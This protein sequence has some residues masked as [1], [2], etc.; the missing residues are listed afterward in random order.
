[1]KKVKV[2]TQRDKEY[3]VDATD[4]N[5]QEIVDALNNDTKITLSIGNMVKNKYDIKMIYLD[6]ESTEDS[7]GVKMLV[8]TIEGKQH[9]T[10][11]KDYDPKM[12]SDLINST[13]SLFV[14]VGNIILWRNS[15]G[16]IFPEPIEEVVE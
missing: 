6:G 12:L 13:G 8:E 4:Y 7:D 16:L 3:T 15:I 1:M 9:V 11:V 5:G 2:T 14:L 10:R